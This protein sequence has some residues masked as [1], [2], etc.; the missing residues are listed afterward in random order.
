MSFSWKSLPRPIVGLSAMDGVSDA[1]MRQITREIGN[2]DFMVT[3]FTSADGL[4]YGVSKLLR[5]FYYTPLQRPIIAQI[6]GANPEKF[7]IAA[8]ISCALGFDGIDINMGCP[9]DSIAKKGGGAS[10]ILNPNLAK[11]IVRHVQ[12][13]VTDWTNGIQLQ[14]IGL[15]KEF[16]K[17][18]ETRIESN[19]QDLKPN[20]RSPLPV[21][22]KTRI[23]YE[24]PVTIEWVSHLLETEPAVITLHGRTL[25]Q[26]YGG[27]ANWE[28]IGKAA[29]FVHDQSDR[30]LLFGNGD[31]TTP[32]SIVSHIKDYSV[33]GVWIG[34]AAM[35]NPWIFKQYQDFVNTGSYAEP[36]TAERFEV[37]IR[38]AQIFEELNNT[39]F[40]A[41]PY[42]F[43]N[44]RKHLGWYVK[45]FPNASEVRQKL[46]QTNSAEEVE[47]LLSTLS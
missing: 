27:E 3:E 7:Y 5:D 33:D 45:G 1:A 31:L 36:T 16:L 21:S 44:M 29:E 10:L 47:A 26:H 17:L 25:E 2:P 35:G 4:A 30:T 19:T 13:G 22:V 23:G 40:A 32:E 12:R 39:V 42:P 15:T 14:D 20:T 46:F 28:E 6:F 37:A 38:H 43:L 24:K 11:D 8:V 9:A 18:L 41:D 34:R